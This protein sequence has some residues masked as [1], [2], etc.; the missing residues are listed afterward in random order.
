MVG[1]SKNIP[2]TSMSS[3]EKENT[4]TMDQTKPVG[5]ACN[6]D[7]TLK[8]ASEL[9]WPDSP[10]QPYTFGLQDN[11]DLDGVWDHWNLDNDNEPGTSVVR[12]VSSAWS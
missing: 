7:G 8:D 10:I 2:N 1:S 6:E 4:Y 5:E 12:N 3:N 9:D 11:N